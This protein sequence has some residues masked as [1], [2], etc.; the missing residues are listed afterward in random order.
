MAE[1]GLYIHVPFCATK[2]GYCDFYSHVPGKGAFGPLVDA[3]LA[4]LRAEVLQRDVR[5]VTIFIGGGTPTLLPVGELGRLMSA[6]S[7]I[8]QRDRPIEFTVEANPASLTDAKAA[9]LREAGVGRVSMGAQS[10]HA[11]E[12]RALDRIHQPHD[13]PPSAEIIRRTGFE[14][15]NLDLIF[16]IPGQTAESWRESIDRAI[17]LGPD[18]LACYGLTYE[19]GTPLRQRLDAGLI[20]PSPEESEAE[21][22]LATI[23][24]LAGAGFEQYEISNYARPGARSEHN[25][26]Y[27]RNQP[28]IGLGPSAASYYD[29]RRAR[30]V[31]DTA[32]YVRRIG[33]GECPAIDSERLDPLARAGETAMLRLRL[34]E[35]IDRAEFAAQTGFEPGQL[36]ADVIVPYAAAGLL[37]ADAHRITLTRNG[38]LLADTIIAD[39]LNPSP[40][41]ARRA[42]V[43]P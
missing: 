35:G 39:F 14:H 23:D 19:S 30:N 9:V 7:A 37:E 11:N 21:L 6:L 25:L 28:V 10:F 13:I 42:V 3:L 17:D 38:L 32:E 1:V 29:G 15:F 36:F 26:R 8:A 43:R 33:G 4:E 27:W 24:H 40:P 12:L 31:P 34:R 16:G 20:T 22:Y 41:R 18:H 5:V 2:C